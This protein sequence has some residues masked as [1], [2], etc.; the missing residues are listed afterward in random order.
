MNTLIPSGIRKFIL[1]V[2]PALCVLAAGG[3]TDPADA[4]ITPDRTYFGVNRPIP[5]RVAVPEGRTG[6]VAIELLAPGPGGSA[7]ATVVARAAAEAGGVDLAGLFPILWTSDAPRALYAQLVVGGTRVGPAVVLQPLLTP[8]RARLA[9]NQVQFPDV[10][11]RVYSGLRAYPDAHIVFDTSEGEIEV[12]L[13][14]D[15]A[16][17]TVWSIRS[18]AEGGYYTDIIVHRVVPNVRGNPFVVQFGDPTGVGSGGPGYFTDLEP[19]SLPHDFG[20]LSMARTNDPDT[21]GSQIFI[22]LSRAGTSFLDVNY[23]SFGQTVRGADAILRIER[24]PLEG[25]NSQRPA[26]PPV[27]R[28]ARLVP[29][30]P[31]GS[32]PAP[33]SRPTGVDNER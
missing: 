10:P 16:P 5:M 33:V 7:D 2:G 3:L 24:T 6:D 12:A 8:V 20:V 13:R 1:L 17:N 9:G 23:V 31:F 4:Q 21:N 25:P 27:I 29:A 11:G 15:H 22:C 32:G 18:L 28:G 26:Q 14:P 19:S 30:P